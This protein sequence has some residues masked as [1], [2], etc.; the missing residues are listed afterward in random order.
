M[1][2]ADCEPLWTRLAEFLA[3]HLGLCFGPER[4]EDLRRGM[5][6]AA[7]EFGFKTPESCAEWLLSAP[8]NKTQID[9]LAGQLTVG[10]TYFFRHARSFEVLE[11]EILPELL[12]V[13]RSGLRS[14]R[15]WSAGC[16]TGEEPYSLAIL[17][18]RSIPDWRR[19]QVSILA[20][21]I[22]V[23]FLEQAAAGVFRDWSFR[24]TPP[25]FKENYFQHLGGGRY[26]ILPYL[27]QLV[28]FSYLNLAADTY[29]SLLNN[30]NAMDVILCRNVLMYFTAAQATR[31]V[32]QLQRC[33]IPGGWLLCSPTDNAAASP[34]GLQAVN[35]PGATVYRQ[36]AG[37]PAAVRPTLSSAPI[38]AP[39]SA[40]ASTKV[41]E[42][43][44]R[45]SPEPPAE[46]PHDA[47]AEP[48]ALYQ[49]GHYVQASDHLQSILARWPDD[50]KTLELLARVYADQG[51]LSEAAVWSER[52]MAADKLNAGVYYLHAAILQEQG[53]GD[54]AVRYLNRALYLDPD[55]VLAHFS[56]ASLARS[57][58]KM[59][60]AEKHFK[61]ALKL[62][63]YY[64]PEELV[65][66]SDGVT[67]GRF[68]EM[69]TAM[70]AS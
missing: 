1:S 34:A 7:E 33:L 32:G 25:G 21:D 60:V 14:L 68:R 53:A 8:L 67:A 54:D 46:P 35:F 9:T 30:T 2:P 45:L 51:R 41:A 37:D 17:L 5:V 23:R 59:A 49:Q 50:S 4:R 70:I 66:E 64:C 56:L 65:P 28:S 12:A 13:R 52:A 62:L 47:Y 15:V 11:T 61:Q 43:I 48:L 58:G 22:N 38:S 24:D 6:G 16:C 63:E 20:T 19:W 40:A 26:E 10:E 44:A 31:V 18:T 57:Q 39:A 36:T 42:Q 69:I 55:F 3:T 27:K 29:P